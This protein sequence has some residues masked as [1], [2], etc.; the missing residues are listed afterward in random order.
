MLIKNKAIQEKNMTEENLGNIEKNRILEEVFNQ[1]DIYGM[2]ID[3]TNTIVM[4]NEKAKDIFGDVRGKK[5]YEIH[6]N[7]SSPPNFCA[8]NHLKNGLPGE[9]LF[10]DDAVTKK[11]YEVKVSKIVLEDKILYVHLMTDVSEINLKEQKI[12]ELNHALRLLNKIL[13]HDILNYIA[14]VSM[15]TE[16]MKTEDVGLK[17][18]ALRSLNKSVELINK[19]RDLESAISSGGELKN[20]DLKEV[21][22]QVFLNFIG[23]NVNILGDSTVKADEALFSVFNNLI[24]NAVIHGKTNKIDIKIENDESFATVRIIDYGEGIPQDVKDNV[25]DEGFSNAG[26]RMGL[27]LYI[28]K[29]TIERYGGEISIENTKPCGTTFILKLRRN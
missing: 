14:V 6:H 22:N 15:S 29:K 26:K 16:L 8:M 11:W 13:R 17:Q 23:I 9:E 18:K 25:F 3:D 24:N 12:V 1:M 10:F 20:Y 5:C 28:V 27:G 4:I 2:V 21:L 19:M 7:T